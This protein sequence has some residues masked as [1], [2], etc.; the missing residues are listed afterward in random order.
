MDKCQ[1]VCH[2][3]DMNCKIEIFINNHWCHAATFTPAPQ[4]I[5]N[6]Y[7]GGGLLCYEITF[8]GEHLDQL[9][10]ALSCGYPVNFEHYHGEQWPA[11]LLDILPSGA[12]RRYWLQQLAI[13]DGATADWQ[14]LLSG[15]GNPPGNI[16]IANATSSS[17]SA[18]H[19]GFDYQEV[20]NRGEY[21]IEY[22]QGHGAPVS[23]SSGAQGD[24]PKFL[25]TQDREGQW[26]ADGA[27]P[28]DQATK[29]WLVK[30]PR[31]KQPS[32]RAVL[33]NEAS[34]Y[35]VA[36]QLG[37]TVAG[38]L[39]FDNNALF[40]PRFDRV[41]S[42]GQI[43]RLGLE[44][45]CSLAGVSEFGAR[46]SQNKLLDTLAR[47]SSNPSADLKEFIY[48]DIL[49]VAMGNTDNHP[50]NSAVL[51]VGNQTRLSPLF[52]FAPMILDDQ[53]IARSCRWEGD[54]EKAG[55]PEWG[56]VAEFLTPYGID[57]NAFRQELQ[58]F[59]SQIEQLPETLQQHGVDED[60]IQRLQPRI[61][62]VFHSLQRAAL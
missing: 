16:R 62:N 61:D 13:G 50:R 39:A 18:T 30:Y 51:K 35:G 5:N 57:A 33:R 53:G 4:Q 49:N 8:V 21:F 26:H 2:Y 56:S 6:G 41:V 45:L 14:L 23:G 24:A 54:A 36:Q 27:L 9:E 32:D 10:A 52:D 7:R 43:A 47:Y 55:R 60:L 1:D 11:F 29:H 37:I 34:Y 20:I 25:L 40:I 42:N 46:L 59:A 48:R 58:Q 3:N 38:P 31:G 44:S 17:S 19:P 15:A 28:D 22:A 12:G